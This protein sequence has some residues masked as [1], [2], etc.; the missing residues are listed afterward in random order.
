MTDEDMVKKYLIDFKN[1]MLNDVEEAYDT[2]NS[3][4][5]N[6]KYN[7]IDEFIQYVNTSKSLSLYTLNVEKYSI[8]NI[9]G[10]KY[11]DIYGTDG[12][13]YIIK[14]ISIMN[15]EVFLDNYTVEI[16]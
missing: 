9:N 6:L 2:L 3:E 11:F 14:E 10:Y 13:R 7:S 8:K 1:L 15:Y 5:R 12:N 4:Y 16:K